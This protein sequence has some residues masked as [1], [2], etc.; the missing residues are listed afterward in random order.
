MEALGSDKG[1]CVTLWIVSAGTE[2][3]G[4]F[5]VYVLDSSSY[6]LSHLLWSACARQHGPSDVARVYFSLTL[7]YHPWYLTETPERL[8]PKSKNYSEADSR[9]IHNKEEKS[10][11]AHL[12]FFYWT[13]S[14]YNVLGYLR[15]LS[16]VDM[17]EVKHRL[18]MPPSLLFPFP[19][20]PVNLLCSIRQPHCHFYAIYTYLIL[21][22]Y[23]I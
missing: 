9:S 5:R 12:K 11:G 4:V 17:L 2:H 10:H 21:C 19:P 1:C 20:S 14:L 18:P 22:V 7:L 16:Y 6:E 8:S 23:K 15:T 3:W 13:Y